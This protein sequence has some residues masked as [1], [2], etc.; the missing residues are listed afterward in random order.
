MCEFITNKDLPE[1]RFP[2]S[3]QDIVIGRSFR[4]SL[5]CLNTSKAGWLNDHHLDLW[6][7]LMWSLRP[8]EADWAIVSPHFSTCILTGM[9]PWKAVKKVYFPVNEPKTHWCL[10]ELEIRTR[11]V[12]FYDSLGRAGGS[13][14]CWWRRMKK[15]LPEKLSVYLV[16]HGIFQSKGISAN[17]YNTSM[18]MLH[19]KH[20]YLATVR[21]GVPGQDVASR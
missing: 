21:Y 15:L 4:L 7:D 18:L 9:M 11:V 16:M 6:I 10:D 1:Y 3:K 2:W 8:P 5:S 14:R 12:T 19:F 17:D 13:R 20:R